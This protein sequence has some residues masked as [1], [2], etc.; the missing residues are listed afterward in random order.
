MWKVDKCVICAV[1]RNTCEH[2][3]IVEAGGRRLSAEA[4]EAQFKRM[5][6]VDHGRRNLTCKSRLQIPELMADSEGGDEW[7]RIVLCYCTPVPVITQCGVTVCMQR[8]F[9]IVAVH[10]SLWMQAGVRWR[11]FC[12]VRYSFRD[13]LKSLAHMLQAGSRQAASSP[14]K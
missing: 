13:P 10:I 1:H 9:D 6:N 8:Q 14:K 7:P 12:L 5:F 11:S 2:V 3:Q 4:A